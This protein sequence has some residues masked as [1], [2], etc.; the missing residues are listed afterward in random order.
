MTEFE[1][2]EKFLDQH[3][4]YDLTDLNDGFDETTIKYF[5]EKDF[6]KVLDRAEYFE[7]EIYGIESWPEG[8]YHATQVFE[9]SAYEAS[10]P[11]W[12]RNA[13]KWFLKNGMKSHF[14][15]SYGVPP[16]LIKLFNK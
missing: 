14:S 13:F 3:V 10:D 8:E 7:I 4:F 15:A 12:Y 11:N 16:H 2:K 6:K 1:I 5:S 9:E